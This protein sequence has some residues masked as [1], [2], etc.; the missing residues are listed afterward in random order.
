[1][2]KRCSWTANEKVSFRLW[3][4]WVR[5]FIARR[6]RPIWRMRTPRRCGCS[7]NVRSLDFR[8]QLACW[9]ISISAGRGLHG[10]I[11]NEPCRILRRQSGSAWLMRCRTWRIVRF[12]DG[13]CVEIDI[14]PLNFILMPL[15]RA[16]QEAL[17]DCL[18]SGLH[19]WRAI[20][21]VV[22]SQW[23]EFLC[24]M[25]WAICFENQ[26]HR[27]NQWYL[28][29]KLH[30]TM[31]FKLFRIWHLNDENLLIWWANKRLLFLDYGVI[32]KTIFLVSVKKFE[33]L[34][35]LH[36]N[37]MLTSSTVE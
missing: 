35:F 27:F 7:S 37:D 28:L 32:F 24:L 9:G 5:N 4:G 1:M 16:R 10:R 11:T 29:D 20:V 6:I 30:Q 13:V 14:A 15:W 25:S 21:S 34:W 3:I 26:Q 17:T 36:W 12:G 18:T 8:W 31:L 22:I 23:R 2:T 33:V 19:F